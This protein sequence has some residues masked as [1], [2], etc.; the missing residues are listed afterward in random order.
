MSIH[1]QRTQELD[2]YINIF[3]ISTFGQLGTINIQQ[4]NEDDHVKLSWTISQAGVTDTLIAA[5][6]IADGN[7]Y[8]A[9][10]S[11]WEAYSEIDD[12][13]HTNLW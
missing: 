9:A 11:I 7:Q 1:T 10:S 8:T 2:N 13:G 6:G 4:T 5:I 12:G 3:E